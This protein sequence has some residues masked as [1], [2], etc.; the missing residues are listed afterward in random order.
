[1][2]PGSLMGHDHDWQPP[3]KCPSKGFNQSHLS[4]M[5]PSEFAKMRV[6][7]LLSKF[8]KQNIALGIWLLFLFFLVDSLTEAAAYC[9]AYCVRPKIVLQADAWNVNSDVAHSDEW[10]PR[11]MLGRILA[12][13]ATPP[14]SKWNWE[15]GVTPG[16][17]W[18]HFPFCGEE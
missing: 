16:I 5:V 7:V 3:C 10:W 17:P 18:C 1:M 13:G 11:R 14:P 8:A 6:R 4:L 12:V 2:I 9:E 15:R